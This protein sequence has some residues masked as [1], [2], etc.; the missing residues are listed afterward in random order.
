MIKKII[1]LSVF[2]SFVFVNSNAQV[3]RRSL[4]FEEI[5]T[6]SQEPDFFFKEN[7]E[8]SI[9]TY[10]SIYYILISKPFDLD[11]MFTQQYTLPVLKNY[12]NE[13]SVDV[14]YY[15]D[16]IS[17]FNGQVVFGNEKDIEEIKVQ[18]SIRELYETN[19][20]FDYLL[21]RGQRSNSRPWTGIAKLAGLDPILIEEFKTGDTIDSLLLNSY[22]ETESFLE[23]NNDFLEY[24]DEYTPFYEKNGKRVVGDWAFDLLYKQ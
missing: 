24:I 5:A 13:V 9:K 18:L 8:Y 21:L 10:D 17:N 2:F 6:I 23:R 1:L 3:N 19:Q 11:G 14:L 4:T 22:Q 15:F 16:S 12:L 7:V 20:F